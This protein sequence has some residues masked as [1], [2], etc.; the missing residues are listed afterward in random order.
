MCVPEE[1][2][3]NQEQEQEPAQ[4]S[5]VFTEPHPA[6]GDGGHVMSTLPTLML[7]MVTNMRATKS[8][9][10]TSMAFLLAET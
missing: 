10:E 9:F 4:E 8:A 6:A 2:E 1:E 7:R 5:P 3:V